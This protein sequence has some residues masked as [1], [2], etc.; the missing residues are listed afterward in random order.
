MCVNQTFLYFSYRN[1]NCHCSFFLFVFLFCLFSISNIAFNQEKYWNATPCTVAELLHNQIKTIVLNYIIRLSSNRANLLL[2]FRK[3]I[4]F[5]AP[6]FIQTLQRKCILHFPVFDTL[7]DNE[8]MC[9]ITVMLG[10]L[11]QSPIIQHS[12]F[13]ESRS[14]RRSSVVLPYNIVIICTVSHLLLLK[15]TN[16]SYLSVIV[17]FVFAF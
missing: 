12:N 13:E 17:A 4:I 11:D 9:Y 1:T 16:C 7:F 2:C 5:F 14:K 8:G 3:S 6:L 10:L 15:K